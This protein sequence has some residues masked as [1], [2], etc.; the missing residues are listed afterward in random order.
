M[1]PV[2]ELCGVGSIPSHRSSAT[3]W[4]HRQRVSIQE[5]RTQGGVAHFVCVQDLPLSVQDAWRALQGEMKSLNLGSYSDELH[6]NFDKL[7]AS[8]QNKA[9]RKEEIGKFIARLDDFLTWPEKT[10]MVQAQFGKAGNGER[11]LRRMMAD[12]EGV[13]P[14]N[15]APALAP[16]HK[17]RTAKAETS[18]EAWRWFLSCSASP[19]LNGR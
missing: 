12:L 6:R 4:L 7:T 11:S 13:D 17:G 8:A 18:E 14:I 19:P 16:K 5:I 2:K 1:I 15:W 3:K 9:R 10:A